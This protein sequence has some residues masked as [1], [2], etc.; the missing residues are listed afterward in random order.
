DELAVLDGQRDVA[1]RLDL[2]AVPV[3]DL[4]QGADFQHRF[5]SILSA[6][7]LPL[8]SAARAPWYQFRTRPSTSRKARARTTPSR[9]RTNTPLHISGIWKPRWNSMTV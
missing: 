6:V 4:A 2:A 7:Q 9:P 8:R 5:P 3:V 1:E